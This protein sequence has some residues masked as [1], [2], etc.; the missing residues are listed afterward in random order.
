MN[1]I[2]ITRRRYPKN[3]KNEPAK[4]DVKAALNTIDSK[5]TSIHRIPEK[6]EGAHH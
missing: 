5:S 4:V 2:G 3:Q 1:A 6:V